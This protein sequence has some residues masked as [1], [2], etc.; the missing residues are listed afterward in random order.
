[1]SATAAPA[2]VSGNV[3]RTRPA[4]SDAAMSDPNYNCDT[5]LRHGFNRTAW[6]IIGVV[7]GIIVVASLYLYNNPD[8]DKS[9]A[10]RD[11]SPQAELNR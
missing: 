8:G 6:I 2:Q 11:E 10:V 4:E 9:S 7:A 5:V 1:M 3:S